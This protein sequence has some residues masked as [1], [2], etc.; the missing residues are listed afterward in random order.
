MENDTD[1]HRM[2]RAF[3]YNKEHDDITLDSFNKALAVSK[4]YLFPTIEKAADIKDCIDFFSTYNSCLL[5][6]YSEPDNY[7]SD[8]KSANESLL[9]FLTD[10]YAA[11][12]NNMWR[13]KI[14]RE[15]EKINMN[16]R[17]SIK[18]ENFDKYCEDNEK[19]F[20]ELIERLNRMFEDKSLYEKVLIELNRRKQINIE[21]AADYGLF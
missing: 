12:I 17:G 20:K 9:Y 21:R 3:R 8:N 15:K 19:Y 1:E 13:A 2:L 5:N 10:D 16:L 4:K 11:I 18:P 7:F 6:L 14:D